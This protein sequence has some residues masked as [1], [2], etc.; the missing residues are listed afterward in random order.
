MAFVF[1]LNVFVMNQIISK[2]NVLAEEINVGCTYWE[3]LVSN[4]NNYVS[5]KINFR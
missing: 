5:V 1:V 2:E 3:T 4:M